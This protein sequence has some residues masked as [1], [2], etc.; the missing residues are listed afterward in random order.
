M[1][2]RGKWSRLRGFVYIQVEFWR[3][4]RDEYDDDDGSFS[5][6]L[7]HDDEGEQEFSWLR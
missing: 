4:C 6:G 7:P 2:G 5:I 1:K 3:V